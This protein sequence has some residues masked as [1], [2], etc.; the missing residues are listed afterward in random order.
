MSNTKEKYCSSFQVIYDSSNS[1]SF[2]RE[3][4]M[5][6]SN[7]QIWRTEVKFECNIHK[8][9]TDPTLCGKLLPSINFLEKVKTTFPLLQFCQKGFLC[10]LHESRKENNEIFVQILAFAIRQWL[11]WT[12]TNAKH[13]K[14]WKYKKEDVKNFNFP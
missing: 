13:W 10:Y 12:K 14:I 3:E 6:T 9:I 1:T 7:T 4:Y 8:N 2:A 5:N 11:D